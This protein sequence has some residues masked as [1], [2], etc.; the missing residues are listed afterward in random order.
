MYQKSLRNRT[1]S[2]TQPINTS[3][4]LF[5]VVL[6]VDGTLYFATEEFWK[7]Y[8]KSEVFEPQRVGTL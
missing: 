2:P 1:S 3:P 8:N 4:F 7:Q 6:G 5:S